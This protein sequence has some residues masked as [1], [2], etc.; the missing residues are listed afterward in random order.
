MRR[1]VTP[2]EA[3]I[4]RLS[5]LLWRIGMWLPPWNIFWWI[6]G[7]TFVLPA[8]WYRENRHALIIVAFLPG[9]M[10]SNLLLFPFNA[11]IRRAHETE[12]AEKP[13]YDHR[14]N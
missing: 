4:S 8:M 2:F 11:K 1:T 12:S 10:L 13:K 3:K 14:K 6:V 9:M 5:D 7:I